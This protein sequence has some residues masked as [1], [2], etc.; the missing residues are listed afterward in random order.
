MEIA[1][2]RFFAVVLCVILTI[3]MIPL[4]ALIANS[5]AAPAQISSVDTGDVY[6]DQAEQPSSGSN[7]S[8]LEFSNPFG[9]IK[10]DDWFFDDVAFVYANGIMKGTGTKQLGRE[11]SLAETPMFS[12]NMP[13]SRAMLVTV[14]YR[15]SGSPD[16]L[17]LL[18]QFTDVPEG[19]WYESAVAWAAANRITTGIGGN[20][21]APD[22]NITREQAA[23]L[24]SEICS[25][26]RERTF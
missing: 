17:G 25:L 2:K 24:F 11:A 14:L 26:Y 9:D 21:F 23:T 5:S 15:L 8:G 7:G 10:H 18:N 22:G 4:D 3:A 16:T 20:L 13:M 1:R 12:P 19:S 6:G